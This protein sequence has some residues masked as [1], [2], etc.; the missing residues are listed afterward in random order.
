MSTESMEILNG[1]WKGEFCGSP[2]SAAI[3]CLMET[4][5]MLGE[6]DVRKTLQIV[7]REGK[8]GVLKK[9]SAERGFNAEQKELLSDAWGV[10]VTLSTWS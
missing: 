3:N 9:L 10:A 6:D 4:L 1:R 8:E 7:N 2:N 5:T